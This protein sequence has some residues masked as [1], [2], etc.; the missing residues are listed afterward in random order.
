MRLFTILPLIAAAIIVIF[1]KWLLDYAEKK[2]K[3]EGR[4]FDRRNAFILSMC[5]VGILIIKVIIFK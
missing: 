4:P 5:A 1:N 2:Y 3:R